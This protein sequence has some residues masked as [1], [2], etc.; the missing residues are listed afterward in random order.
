MAAIEHDTGAVSRPLLALALASFGIGTTEY[1]IMGLLPDVAHNLAVNVPRAGLLVT[2]YALGVAFGGPLVAAL[3]TGMPRRRALLALMGIFV[4][5]NLFCALAPS[6]SLLRAA[7]IVTALCHGAFFGVGAVVAAALVVPQ[8]RAQAIAL[9]IA[10]LTL[11]NV[12]GVPSGTA[13][14]NALGWR[15]TFWAIA[16]IGVAAMVA[17]LNWLPHDLPAPHVA[18]GREARALGHRQVMLAM[19]ISVVSSASLF[20]VFA[21]I[22]PLLEDVTGLHDSGVTWMLLL[23][24]AGLTCGNI[25]GGK[26][27]DWR[28]MSALIGILGAL[29]AVM[30]ALRW[31]APFHAFVAINLF[32]WGVLAFA[33]ISPLQMRVLN[34]AAGAPNLASTVNQS[35]F[36]LGNAVGAWI[37]S[38]VLTYGLTY[39][40]LPVIGAALAAIAL[41][42]TIASCLLDRKAARANRANC[43]RPQTS[44]SVLA[45]ARER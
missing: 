23:F 45:R 41:C 20:S 9:M 17:L 16:A 6:Y 19:L 7:R 38:V 27:G 21:F 42:L 1:V 30:I 11:A 22:S 25:I 2:G 18:L 24:G 35:A 5:G 10:G 37:G 34:G 3:T 32:C 13:L 8:E 4:L 12:L 33:L 40:D 15:S 43:D 39:D 44:Y 36:N 28:A 29:I 26:L 31:T 14:G